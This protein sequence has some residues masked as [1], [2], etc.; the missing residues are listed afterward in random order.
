MSN[1]IN[2][3]E[4]SNEIEERKLKPIETYSHT[5]KVGAP[6]VSYLCLFDGNV[7][8]R[9][10]RAKDNVVVSEFDEEFNMIGNIKIPVDS[11]SLNEA[12]EAARSHWESWVRT[13]ET[14]KARKEL[15]TKHKDKLLAEN[16]S[17]SFVGD[18]DN[19]LIKVDSIQ[20]LIDI[21]QKF[22]RENE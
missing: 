14:I 13:G 21:M 18:D 20:E 6:I 22:V 7:R 5:N 2:L 3:K 10:R 8:F 4:K 9:L 12:V 1:I 15:L 19:F 11:K 17:I 16:P